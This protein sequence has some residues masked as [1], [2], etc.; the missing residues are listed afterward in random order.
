MTSAPLSTWGFILASIRHYWRISAAV[1]I[2]VATATAV[3]TG[4]L[5]VGDSMRGSLADLTIQR[6]GSTESMVAPMGFFDSDGIAGD[7]LQPIPLIYFPTGIAESKVDSDDNDDGSDLIRRAGSV[8][9]IGIDQDFWNLDSLGI[10]PAEFPSDDGVVINASAA[11]ELGVQKGDL[12]TVRLPA[13]QAVPAD[14]PLGRRD[15]TSEGLPRMKVVAVI[16]DRGLGRF[17]LSPSQ[18]APQNIYVSRTLIGEVL[19]RDGQANMLLF[20]REIETGDLNVGVDDLGLSLRRITKNF[21]DEAVFDYYTLTSDRLLLPETV[22]D[23]VIREFGSQK[24]VPITTY[25]ANAIERLDESGAVVASVPYSTITAMD[26][27]NDVPLDF[28]IPASESSKSDSTVVPLVINSWASE[29]LGAEVGTKLRV[30]YYEP[31]VE[32]GKEI[33]R[34][35][36]AVVTE[37]VPITEPSR[38]YRRRSAA[39]FDQPPTV[40]NDPDLTPLVPGVTD[41]DSISDW[42]LPFQLQRKINSAD[43]DYWNDYRLTP[44][45]FLPLSEGH[46]LFGSRFGDTTSLRIDAAAATDLE[47][48]QSKINEL[49]RPHLSDLGW[50]AIPIRRQQLAASRGTTPFDGLFLALSFFVIAAAVLL[51]AMLLRLGL[52]ER[53]QQMG[54]MMA[55][56]WTPSTTRAAMMGEGVI[57]SGIGAMLGIVGGIAYAWC[58]LWA[59]RT[60][61]V[62]AV[63]V[64]FLTFHYTFTSLAIG[65][66]AGFAT[67]AMTLWFTTRWLTKVN[68][69]RLLGGGD[70][71]VVSY[72][73]SNTKS[74]RIPWIARGM[75]VFALLLGCFGAI[76]GGQAAAGGFIGGGMMLLMA[77]LLAIFHRLAQGRHS[78]GAKETPLSISRLST[79]NASRRPLRS[80]MTIGLMAVASFLIIAI[81]AFR[82]QPSE[83]GTGGFELMAR[84]AQPVFIDLQDP[85]ARQETFGRSAADLNEITIAPMRLR[86]GQDASCNN[87]YQATKPTVI[88]VPTKFGNLINRRDSIAGFDWASHADLQE[89]ETPWDNLSRH[90]SGT[91]SDPIPVVIDQNTA[92]W[93][94]QMT[95]GIGQ[96][97]SFE[98]EAGKPV[99]FEVVGLLSN[100]VLQGQLLIGETNF[101]T[102]FPDISGYQFFLF[103]TP[104]EKADTVSALLE[105]RL[106][107]VGMDVSSASDVLAGMLAVQNTYLRTFQSLGALGLLLGTVGLAVAQIRS[108]IERRSELAVMRSMGFTRS[109]LSLMVITETASL[110]VMGIGCGLLCAVLAVLPHAWFSGVRPPIVEPVMIVVGILLFGLGAGWLATRRISRMPLIDSLRAQ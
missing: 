110:L 77:A 105:S 28:T 70:V 16:E 91:E 31:E 33:E 95:G 65:A 106:G 58:V 20:D 92:M 61:W 24:V 90:A 101:E 74:S 93:S 75:A 40:Y 80:T 66:I 47:S 88:G 21:E 19:D 5:L 57:T 82:L 73:T 109:R 17:S 104:A 51:I 36:D 94:L 12:I 39:Q 49:L 35:F 96:V 37:V 46:R 22:V 79:L 10:R 26:S 97:K 41:Q 84:S 42:D 72:S 78:L 44:K 103:D 23:E 63:T 9:I 3:I 86:L 89:G 30:A 62:G 53:T 27:S 45:A 14:S 13:E 56:G 6:L 25:L 102:T 8:Q 38:P 11:D 107:D 99:F 34:Y 85:K 59:L 68:A 48:L 108:V 55:M 1:A 87:L 18:A 50:E 64:P 100:S 81:S 69:Q 83:G 98:Y 32:N 71:D 43:D 4:A 67:A 15:A 76:S 7:D 2:G 29:Q 52:T 54:T 60:A